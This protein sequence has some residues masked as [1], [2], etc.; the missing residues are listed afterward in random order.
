MTSRHLSFAQAKAS[1]IVV[2]A[3]QTVPFSIKLELAKAA[4]N[5]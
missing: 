1:G 4:G 3:S 5:H 2:E